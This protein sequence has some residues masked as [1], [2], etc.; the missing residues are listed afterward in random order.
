MDLQICKASQPSRRTI[1]IIEKGTAMSVPVTVSPIPTSARDE[2][3]MTAN[4]LGFE[5]TGHARDGWARSFR[6]GNWFMWRINGADLNV[7]YQTAYLCPKANRYMY[8]E[9]CASMRAASVR[10]NRERAAGDLL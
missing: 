3:I 1:P 6:K 7:A 9:P 4:R 2:E 5:V 10:I 8:H